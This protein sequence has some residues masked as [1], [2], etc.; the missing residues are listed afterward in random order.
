MPFPNCIKSGFCALHIAYIDPEK[1]PEGVQKFK[2][3][4]SNWVLTMQ[5]LAWYTEDA[6]GCIEK[7]AFKASKQERAYALIGEA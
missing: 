4:R 1:Q 3:W 6:I 7:I 5:P 2:V